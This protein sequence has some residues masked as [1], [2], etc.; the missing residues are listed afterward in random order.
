MPH[1]FDERIDRLL[2]R[3]MSPAHRGGDDVRADAAVDIGVYVAQRL[4]GEVVRPPDE[5]VGAERYD[6]LAARYIGRCENRQR[7]VLLCVGGRLRT[8][9]GDGADDAIL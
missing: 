4:R 2:Q 5:E 8:I 9:G 1:I 7:R 6:L 3:R